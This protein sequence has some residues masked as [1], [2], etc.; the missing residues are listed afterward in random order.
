MSTLR[1]WIHIN[2][3]MGRL[4]TPEMAVVS[5]AYWLPEAWL[6]RGCIPKAR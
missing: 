4:I 2:V 1:G 6:I 3:V 5:E